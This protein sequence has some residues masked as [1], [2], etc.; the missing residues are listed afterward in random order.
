[1]PRRLGKTPQNGSTHSGSCRPRRAAIGRNR[2]RHTRIG[3]VPDSSDLFCG[4]GQVG[5]LKITPR[6]LIGHSFGG[7]GDDENICNI[8]VIFLFLFFSRECCHSCVTVNSFLSLCCGSGVE[9][10]GPSKEAA[11]K[12]HSGMHSHLYVMTSPSH[13]PTSSHNILCNSSGGKKKTKNK[14]KNPQK[15]LKK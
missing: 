14:N 8:N 15:K 2:I 4:W 10:G 11:S 1:M 7:K 6:V 13:T 5:Q 3:Y 9:H 12:T